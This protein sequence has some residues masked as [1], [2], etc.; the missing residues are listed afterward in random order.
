[1]Q[2]DTPSAMDLFEL[3]SSEVIDIIIEELC[4]EDYIRFSM[5]CKRNGEICHFTLLPDIDEKDWRRCF[6]ANIVCGNC[7]EIDWS[8]RCGM[9]KGCDEG[10]DGNTYICFNCNRK[11]FNHF[12]TCIY[13]PFT[14]SK[15][16]ICKNGC[17]IMCSMCKNV[18]H[19]QPLVITNT[20][21][22]N[23][24]ICSDCSKRPQEIYEKRP[25]CGM[26]EKAEYDTNAI[27]CPKHSIVLCPEH[28]VDTLQDLYGEFDVR[29]KRLRDLP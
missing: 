19:E 21:S 29:H 1:M 7:R 3:L 11:N 23:N 15:A 10:A 8:T 9:C 14:I 5:T 22:E 2:Q 18:K 12:M 25:K 26:C 6:Y 17:R 16:H 27:F 28:S 24:F 13:K 20:D 4:P